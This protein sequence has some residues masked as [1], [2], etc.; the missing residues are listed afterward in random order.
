M[1]CCFAK[2][3]RLG[4]GGAKGPKGA[5]DLR[6]SRN[7]QPEKTLRGKD[8]APP[9]CGGTGHPA[10]PAK[11][12]AQARQERHKLALAALSALQIKGRGQAGLRG[13]C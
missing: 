7:S 9:W 6:G 1:T 13:L 12:R 3:Q 2:S 10:L 5:R 8:M 4:A 11:T